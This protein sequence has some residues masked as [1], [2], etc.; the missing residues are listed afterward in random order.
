MLKSLVTGLIVGVFLALI[1]TILGIFAIFAYGAVNAP[2]HINL[3]IV[4]L[5]VLKMTITNSSLQMHINPVGLLDICICL[6]AIGAGSFLL[7]QRMFHHPLTRSASHF[8]K[9]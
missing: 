8:E 7:F 9:E 5:N 2:W 3:V 4:S 6:I 1:V